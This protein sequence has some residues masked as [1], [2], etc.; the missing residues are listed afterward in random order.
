M[1]E[2]EGVRRL[3]GK[4]L[5]GREAY[6]FGICRFA[7]LPPLLECRA[8][9]RLPENAQS[10]L[11]CLF[12]YYTG[13]HP[14]RNISRY[15]MVADYHLIA[16]EYLQRF[17]EA[18]RQQFPNNHFEP[19]TD[20]SPVPE[21]RSALLAGLGRRGKNGLLLHPDYGSYVFIGEVVTD[22]ALE[23]DAPL[24]PS[25]CLNCGRCQRACPQGALQPDG[26][27]ELSRCRSHITQKKGELTE[28]EI[29]QIRAG[30]LIWGCDICNDVCPCN[31]EPKI[32][33]VPEFLE[34]AVTVFD[35]EQAEKLLKTRAFNYRGKKT[36]L[37]NIDLL[38]EETLDGK[39]TD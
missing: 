36:I 23:P 15:A 20:N 34:S 3:A 33:P 7:D 28:W 6:P 18:L 39:E 9:Q 2:K 27:V 21:V 1:Q 29:Q 24:S 8:K 13:E 17:C 35:R 4:I 22:L 10:V 38:E 25:D 11:V 30:G 31:R 37:R 5:Q 32:S 16:G 12:P 19:F 26:S 14:E